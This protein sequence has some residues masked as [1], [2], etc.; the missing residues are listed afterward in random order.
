MATV[1]K[2]SL[3]EY[4]KIRVVAAQIMAVINGHKSETVISTELRE[5]LPKNSEF[6]TRDIAQYRVNESASFN[7][8]V[9]KVEFYFGLGRE[10]FFLTRRDGDTVRVIVLTVKNQ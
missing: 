2:S 7:E 10:E 9:E 1:N 6:I 5:E 3:P 8:L 4:T